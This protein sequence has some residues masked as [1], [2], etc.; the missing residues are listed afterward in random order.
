MK[1]LRY[2]VGCMGVVLALLLLSYGCARLSEGQP[3][4]RQERTRE[5]SRQHSRQSG[6]VEG[7]VD[8]SKDEAEAI[9]LTTATAERRPVRHRLAAMGK[10]LADPKLV[11]IVSY[12]FPAR[13]AEAHVSIGDWVEAGQ[14]L[15]TLQSEEVGDAK[16][17]FYEAQASLELAQANHERSRLLHQRG[18]G[19]RKDLVAGEAELK[20]A[21]AQLESAEK[22]LH[23]LGFT[24][25]ELRE[26][27]E[28]HQVNPEITLSAPISGKAARIDVVRGSMIDQGHEILLI[29]DPSH[30]VVDA[31]IYERDIALVR[32]DQPVEIE[33]P[34]FP[35][36]RFEGSISY[37]GDVVDEATRT[38]T[39]RTKV[40]NPNG[41]LKPGMFANVSIELN[42]Q[43]D[44]VVVPASAVIHDN[45]DHRLVFIVANGSYEARL[46]D[47]G[48]EEDGMVE[49][50][51]GVAAG[52]QVVARGAY[53]LKAK[54][55]AGQLSHGHAH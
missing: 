38:I 29:L 23:L 16:A 33:V 27:A 35:S 7:T 21:Q 25:A 13:I 37:V 40:A 34:A 30:L 32:V 41:K 9:D 31:E 43:V 46:V 52:E 50:V 10:V 14:P 4:N 6:A 45:H 17:E 26:I 54:L 39:V 51:A 53:Q 3:A 49:I 36:K 42:Q 18:V 22:K 28:T 15:V 1:S 55:R 2:T 44:A 48:L 24:E 12:A 11:A 8:L 20:V 5:Q 47:V 19:A